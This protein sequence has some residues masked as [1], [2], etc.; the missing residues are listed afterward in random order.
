MTVKDISPKAGIVL[1]AL[2]L[3]GL[4]SPGGM[5]ASPSPFG[6]AY[7][8]GS[9]N[10][11]HFMD[12]IHDLS[13]SR[14]KVSFYW[15][16]LEPEPGIY[17]FTDLDQYLSQLGPDD[18]GLINLF[19]SGWCTEE[20]GP[21]KGSPLGDCPYGR[22]GCRTDCAEHYRAFITAVAERVKEK[23]SGGIKY[24]QRDTEPASPFPHFPADS[25]EAYV[26]MQRIFY[27]AVKSVLPDA[28]VIGCN[29]N[30]NFTAAGE[31]TNADFFDYFLKNAS[32]YFDALDLR[33]YDD[34]Y[35]I[36]PV[37]AGSGSGC[38]PTFTRG[39]SYRPNKEAPIPARCTR[40][41]TACSR[42]SSPISASPAWG[43]APRDVSPRSSRSIAIRS[44]RSSGRSTSRT[45]R[46][47]MRS[48]P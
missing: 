4:S 35:T 29:Q 9:D 7:G 33:L 37:S 14:T 16:K 27:E 2:V 40:T 38:A 15:D 42:R 8:E 34:P 17:D 46:A 36:P 21:C 25:P 18:Q 5:A 12:Y 39:R 6:V 19:T 30:G 20:Q 32:C 44:T 41:A 31:P 1:I 47:R 11:D 10:L 48:T 28:I 22:S 45:I 24:W 26:E 23:G 3:L 43:K 13:L